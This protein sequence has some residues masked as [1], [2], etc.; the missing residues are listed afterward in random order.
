MIKISKEVALKLIYA[1]DNR[2]CLEAQTQERVEEV[3]EKW[4]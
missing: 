4:N 3:L 2:D 1:M